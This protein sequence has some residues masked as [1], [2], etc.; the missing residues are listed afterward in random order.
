MR[1]LSD[2][3]GLIVEPLGAL[4]IAAIP[5]DRDRLAGRQTVSIVRGS[6]V[7]IDA[8]RRAIA[9]LPVPDKS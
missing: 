4:S 8:Y 9:T 5:E 7:D 3:A 1:M 6:S 2:H